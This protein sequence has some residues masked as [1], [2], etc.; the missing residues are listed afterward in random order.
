MDFQYLDC[1]TK[2]TIAYHIRGIE[3]LPDSLVKRSGIL[4]K[5]LEDNQ[6]HILDKTRE[7][8]QAIACLLRVWL[9][10]QTVLLPSQFLPVLEAYAPHAEIALA[11]LKIIQ[12]IFKRVQVLRESFSSA[13]EF[14][15]NVQWQSCQS[16]LK[17][18]GLLG[19]PNTNGKRQVLDSHLKTLKQYGERPYTSTIKMINDSDWQPMEQSMVE[20]LPTETDIER[21]YK[22]DLNRYLNENRRHLNNQLSTAK[23]HRFQILKPDNPPQFA[24]TMYIYAAQLA[25]K[26]DHFRNHIFSEFNATEKR[27]LRLIRNNK[28]LK[29]AYIDCDGNLVTKE[30][31]KR[32]KDKKKRKKQTAKKRGFCKE[33]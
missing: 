18:T 30:K 20:K 23:V 29:N 28:D 17:D 33:K 3:H 6:K 11:R 19:K 31:H 16:N 24:K 12:E 22:N 4:P 1:D 10:N 14:W 9:L 26:D 2:E 5:Y 7:K 25:A 13:I 15:W 32:G 8:Y 21:Q 27:N